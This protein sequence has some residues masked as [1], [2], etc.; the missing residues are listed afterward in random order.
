MAVVCHPAVARAVPDLER[1]AI[2]LELDGVAL[3]GLQID[4][5]ERLELPRWLA[6][7]RGVTDVDLHDLS[8]TSA[9]S[10][11]HR[12]GDADGVGAAVLDRRFAELERRIRESVSEWVQRLLALLVVVAVA[13]Q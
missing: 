1:A 12:H 3:S 7:R 9:A 11:T 13:D 4:S 8:A 5:P 10:V 2:E 6:R